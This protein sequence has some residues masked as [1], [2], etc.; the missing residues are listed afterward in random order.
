MTISPDGK[1]LYISNT[2]ANE[3]QVVDVA[4]HKTVKWIPVGDAPKR[5]LAVTV[6]QF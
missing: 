4:T 6:P 2:K 5:I 1:H 3:V